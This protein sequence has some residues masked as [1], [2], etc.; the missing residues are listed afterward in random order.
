MAHLLTTRARAEQSHRARL[1][2]PA[3]PPRPAYS[4]AIS[5]GLRLLAIRLLGILFLVV[6][7]TALYPGGEPTRPLQ[8]AEP[9][10]MGHST[11]YA[12]DSAE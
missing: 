9:V 5:E 11:W 2:A 8:I 12:S 6:L 3:A 1:L 10:P 7:G 4:P